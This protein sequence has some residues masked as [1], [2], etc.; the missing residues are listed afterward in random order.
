MWTEH[1]INAVPMQRNLQTIELPISQRW[2]G[3]VKTCD[4]FFLNFEVSTLYE[5]CHVIKKKTIN[6]FFAKTK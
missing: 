4:Y 6:C 2:S 3:G 1:N 5:N